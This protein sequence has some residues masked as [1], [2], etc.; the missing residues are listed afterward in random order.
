[1]IFN[2]EGSRSGCICENFAGDT[3]ATSGTSIRASPINSAGPPFSISRSP[4]KKRNPKARA[5]PNPPSF[6]TL[7][8]TPTMIS[9]APRFAPSSNISP[10]PNV[11]ARRTS[12][13]PSFSARNPAASLISIT[14]EAFSLSHT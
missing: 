8:P 7:P 14:A 3:P 5:I 1:M 6:V 2:C 4:V 11:F 10:T 12:R 9:R 13:T